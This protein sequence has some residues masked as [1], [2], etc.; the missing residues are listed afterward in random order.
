MLNY[1][2]TFITLFYLP[3][4]PDLV[5]TDGEG[6]PTTV[7]TE[8]GLYKKSPASAE[9]LYILLFCTSRHYEPN[10]V[11][12]VRGEGAPTTVGTEEG[13]KTRHFVPQRNPILI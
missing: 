7:G 11:P 4:R 3:V 10:V 8:E 5:L 9:Q 12:P 1:L 2:E 13:L 6:V